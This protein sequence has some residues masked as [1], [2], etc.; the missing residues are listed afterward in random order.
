[1]LLERNCS[2]R[3]ISIS[4]GAL[5]ASTLARFS[6]TDVASVATPLD[7]IWEFLGPSTPSAHYKEILEYY[8]TTIYC[9]ETRCQ[10]VA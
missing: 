2:A 6:R 9:G 3:P 7:Q 10:H 5:I 4:Q 8:I 1:M